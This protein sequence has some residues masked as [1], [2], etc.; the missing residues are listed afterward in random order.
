MSKSDLR[1][2]AGMPPGYQSGGMVRAVT[3]PATTGGGQSSSEMVSELR[4]QGEELSR[5]RRD[6]QRF[7][8][9]PNLVRVDRRASRDIVETGEEER[10]RRTR[11][12][13]T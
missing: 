13:Q 8:D 11:G 5:L 2:V 4:R 6:L 10:D 9:R 7:A 3:R 12:S 1:R